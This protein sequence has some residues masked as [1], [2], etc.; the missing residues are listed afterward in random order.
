[1]H[2]NFSGRGATIIDMISRQIFT[3]DEKFQKGMARSGYSNFEFTVH[4]I[5]HD[6]DYSGVIAC[7]LEP[8]NALDLQQAKQESCC[9]L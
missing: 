8:V 7:V 9:V 5:D 6:C 2:T 1:L 3:S 4:K